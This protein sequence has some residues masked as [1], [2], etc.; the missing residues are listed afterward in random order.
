MTDFLS[1]LNPEQRDA[2]L[3][4]NGPLLIL[5][6]AGSGKTRVIASRIAYLIG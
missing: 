2:V 1:Q 6:G 4:L 3:K 5:A